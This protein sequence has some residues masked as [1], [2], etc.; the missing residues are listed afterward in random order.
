M[1]IVKKYI[2]LVL[3][4]VVL[5]AYAISFTYSI[6]DDRVEAMGSYNLVDIHL[7]IVQVLV[8]ALIVLCIGFYVYKVSKNPAKGIRFGIGLGTLAVLGIIAYNTASNDIAEISVSAAATPSE[9]KL[10]GGMV[11]LTVILIGLGLVSLLGFTIKKIIENA[12][13]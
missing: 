4:L 1:E 11:I 12:T 5:V 7:R 2:G 10:V 8:V 13:S 9:Y 6:S 3:G